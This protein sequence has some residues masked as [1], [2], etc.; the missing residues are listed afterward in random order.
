MNKN[1]R[2][3]FYESKK[4]KLNIERKGL[5]LTEIKEKIKTN[6]EINDILNNMNLDVIKPDSMIKN[7]K[8]PKK[9]HT[10]K[11]VKHDFFR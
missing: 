8:F 5:F 1:K 3:A 7:I 4:Q 2:F 6:A 10:R 9:I 11:D